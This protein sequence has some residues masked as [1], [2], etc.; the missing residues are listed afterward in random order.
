MQQS[1]RK[2][3]QDWLGKVIHGEL[4]KRLEFDNANKR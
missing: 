2:L 4:C 3:M 1:N